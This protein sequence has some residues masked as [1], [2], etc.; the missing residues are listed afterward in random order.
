VSTEEPKRGN[1]R[2]E[3]GKPIVFE[4]PRL[5]GEPDV[6]LEKIVDALQAYRNAVQALVRDRYSGVAHQLSP[7]HQQ[8]PNIVILRC[9][10]GVIVR[11]EAC[12]EGKPRIRY[13][14]LPETLEDMAP[15]LS[16]GV[17]HVPSNIETYVMPD[18]GPRLQGLRVNTVTGAQEEIFT[19]RPL[20][21]APSQLPVGTALPPPPARP[22]C[23]ASIVNQIDLELG[24][25]I[26]QAE[27]STS[28]ITA[29]VEQF[30]AT[31]RH[32]LEVGWLA[33]EIYP[34]LPPA[35][36]DAAA[37]PMWAECDLLARIAQEN[38]RDAAL[39]TLDGRGAS[40]R[41]YAELLAEF[42]RLL[43]GHEEPV[44]QFLKQHPELINPS[45]EKAWSKLQFGKRKSD[46]VF[47]E[48]HLDYELVEIEAPHR[49]LFREDGQ[50]REPLVHA[51]NQVW[52][53]IQHVQDN[54]REVEDKQGLVG[55]SA[56]PRFLVVIGR[57]SGLT[58]ENRRKL[59]TMASTIPKLRV[60]TYD[61]VLAAA[62]ANIER[63]LGPLG[64]ESN[65][66][67]HYFR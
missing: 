3:I 4:G 35:H 32:P 42:E 5:T 29:P 49:E 13:G 54:K 9:V 1:M 33:I 37:A 59:E 17:V 64:I 63:L 15:K 50:P 31:G 20:V 47:R 12:T 53:W 41:H 48:P 18:F 46:F 10:D 6:E 28:E 34:I 52:D 58:D 43:A 67:L 51:I 60:L 61:D 8:P 40:R 38:V 57:S 25:A 19:V 14:R 24:G 44:H 65:M 7:H 2:I 16:D 26:G 30:V 21:I 39:R 62:R 55:I 22:L 36:W 66:Q 56:H 11:Y 45:F 23:L 27:R